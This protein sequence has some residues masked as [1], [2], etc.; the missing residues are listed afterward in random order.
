MFSKSLKRTIDF[1]PELIEPWSYFPARYAWRFLHTDRKYVDPMA[2]TAKRKLTLGAFVVA[3]I[4]LFFIYVLPYVSLDYLESQRG[5]FTEYYSRNPLTVIFL[6]MVTSAL[7]IGAALPI[8]ALF[9]LLAGALFGFSIGMVAIS[10]ASTIGSTLVLLWSRYFFRDWLQERFREEFS[11]IN[12]G[13]AEEGAYYVFSARLM[14]IFPMFL[15]NLVCG[16]T[17]IKLSS[18]VIA[19]LL[20][21]TIV[22]SV[23]VY[24]GA[25]M[26]D[27][28]TGSDILSLK[29]MIVFA[30]LGVLPIL[31]HRIFLALRGKGGGSKQQ[32]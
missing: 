28:K 3:G 26:A 8:M 10:I 30:S 5:N 9:A 12:R 20:S 14:T 19:T 32:R 4:A 17:N 13:I 23:W 24:A 29:M 6:Y 11:I 16:L 18:Y 27:L 7:F 25:T 2:M 22:V 31:C 21:Q 1:S 15:I